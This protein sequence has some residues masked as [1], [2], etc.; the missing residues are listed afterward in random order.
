LKNLQIRPSQFI[1]TYGVGSLVD[2]PDGSCIILDFA[3]SELMGHQG[4]PPDLEYVISPLGASRIAQR[5][6]THADVPVNKIGIFRLPTNA[7]ISVNELDAIYKI[8]AFPLWSLCNKH[9][10]FQVLYRRFDNEGRCPICLRNASRT[11]TTLT[12][13]ESNKEV[14]RFIRICP[15]GHMSDVNWNWEVHK[16]RAPHTPS[17]FLWVDKGS[18]LQYVS[19]KCP[20]CNATTTLKD[21][22]NHHAAC[23]GEHP[24]TAITQRDVRKTKEECRYKRN[25]T[26]T[27]IIQRNASSVFV[28]EIIT[29]ISHPK[30]ANAFYRVLLFPPFLS[31]LRREYANRKIIMTFDKVYKMFKEYQISKEPGAEQYLLVLKKINEGGVSQKR[32]ANEIIEYFTTEIIGKPSRI[33]EL[34][35]RKEEFNTFKKKKGGLNVDASLVIDT[36][37]I[38]IFPYKNLKFKVTPI[39][40]LEVIMVQAGFKRI[41]SYKVDGKFEDIPISIVQT[42]Y[43]DNRGNYWYVGAKLQGE[44]IFIELEDVIKLEIEDK[45]EFQKKIHEGLKYFEDL[46]KI[47]REIEDKTKNKIVNDNLKNKSNNLEHRKISPLIK[48]WSKK[49]KFRKM[50]DFCHPLGFWWHT[51]S[52][53]LIKAIGLHSGYSTASLRERLYLNIENAEGGVLIYS[54][55]PGEDGT[56]GGLVSQVSYFDEIIHMALDEIDSC[57]ND[58]ICGDNKMKVGK[59]NGAACYACIFLSETSCEF[60]NIG[61]DRNIIINTLR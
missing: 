18:E 23:R 22:K 4:E 21:I 53:R 9:K 28:P 56:F 35:I 15:K 32:L 57:S 41:C 26:K 19:I 55:R 7:D 42:P 48:R 43:I 24:H 27:V 20:E 12:K 39:P 51:L 60:G 29:S 34:D 13:Y 45:E 52:H 11:G 6:S 46:E 37:N 44:G 25:H 10:T 30:E 1:T 31:E 2:G 54:S 5:L 49:F 3:L 47:N 14:I 33:N 58:P 50:H 16:G 17:F 61:L 40:R 36:N 8:R 59:I 38:K